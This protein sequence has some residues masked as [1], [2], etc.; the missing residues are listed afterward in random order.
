MDDSQIEQQK[1]KSPSQVGPFV[2]IIIIVIIIALGGLY[3]LVKNEL[4]RAPPPG[5]EQANS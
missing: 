2:G 1:L 3:F 4:H 5:Q